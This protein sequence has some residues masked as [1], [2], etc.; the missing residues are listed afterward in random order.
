[1]PLRPARH[2]SSRPPCRRRSSR[3][4][5]PLPAAIPSEGR[6]SVAAG[7]HRPPRSSSSASSVVRHEGLR[8]ARDAARGSIHGA[9]NLKNAIIFCNRKRDVATILY[10]SLQK[11]GF[12]GRGA[13]HGDMEPARAHGGARSASSEGEIADR[14]SPPTSP[15]AASTSPACQPRLQFRRAAPSPEDY[16]H[17]IGRTG[18]AGTSRPRRSPSS[19]ARGR[20]A[21]LAAI[22]KLIGQPIE[23]ASDPITEE[24]A[25]EARRE[26]RG[27][28]GSARGGRSAA[29][30]SEP[31]EGGERPSRRGEQR[32]EQR[33]SPERSSPRPPRSDDA[34]RPAPAQRQASRPDP[35]GQEEADMSHLPQFLL[36]PVTYRG[37]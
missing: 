16:V 25:G 20:T 3:L 7:L 12:Y 29:P 4:A 10:K 36:R 9:E 17:R 28:S 32:S 37:K 6:A 34:N 33:G 22:E 11:H 23:W 21:W 26:R 24:E 2:C 14:W 5:E 8:Q 19:L 18:R 15:P 35:R 30:R 27:S 13:L 31:R 1:M